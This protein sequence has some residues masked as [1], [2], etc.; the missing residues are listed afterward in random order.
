MAP[1][2]DEFMLI[3][4]S[5]NTDYKIAI[6]DSASRSALEVHFVLENTAHVFPLT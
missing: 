4:S 1:G 5:E 6:V 2:F 3:G